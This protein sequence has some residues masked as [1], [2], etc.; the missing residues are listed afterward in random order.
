MRK[1]ET[2]KN[3]IVN[4]KG[5]EVRGLRSGYGFAGFKTPEL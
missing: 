4:Q 1:R 3:I 2:E 5:N